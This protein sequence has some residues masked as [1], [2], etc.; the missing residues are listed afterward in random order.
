[1]T[2]PMA[3]TACLL[4]PSFYVPPLALVS[5]KC[6]TTREIIFLAQSS[7]RDVEGRLYC[8]HS[9][10]PQRRLYKGG[11]RYRDTNLV[12]YFYFVLLLLF[13]F[14]LPDGL[15]MCSFSI[16]NNNNNNNDER[17]HLDD[18]ASQCVLPP[19]APEPQCCYSFSV[20]EVMK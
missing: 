18:F 12:L 10:I 19:R 9:Q 11:P 17:F 4:H 16:N 2:G 8:G 3:E 15:T 5:I 13:V 14:S 20:S 6:R 7:K 1:M